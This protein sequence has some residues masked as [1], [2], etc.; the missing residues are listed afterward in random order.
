MNSLRRL[1]TF[2]HPYRWRYALAALLTTLSIAGDLVTP[3]LFGMTV[4]RGLAS[5][6]MSLVLFYAGLLLVAQ[7]IRSLVNYVQWQVQHRVGQDVVRDMRDSLY[8]KLQSLPTSFYRAMPTGQIMS[9]M[10]SDIDAIQEYLGWGLMIQFAALISF[11]GTAIVL[12]V[13]DPG[14]TSVLL[15]P[16][17]PL[18]LIVLLYDRRIAPAWE[19]IRDHMGELT[20]ALQ[21]N[22]SGV[23]VV[24]A[25][26]K[27]AF[28][29]LKFRKENERQKEYNLVRARIEGSAIPSMDLMIGIAFVLLA[30]YGAQ[31]V[32]N[33]E[34]TLGT[35]FAYQWYLWGIIWPVRFM[36]WLIS[37]MREAMGAAPRIFE[38]LDANNPIVDKQDAAQL[39]QIHGE[40]EFQDVHFAF[41]DEPERAVFK[42]LELHMTPGEVIAILGGTGSGKSSLINLI[43][44]F[45][46]VTGGRL[47]VDGHDVRDV[48]LDSLRAQIA[49]VP[50]EPFLFSS[51][52]RN[53]IAYG[54]PEA[55]MEEIVAAAELARAHDFILDLEKGYDTLVGERGIGLSGGQKQ[56]LALARAILMNPRILILDEATSAVDTETEHAIQQAMEQVMQGRT[57]LIIAQRL[58]TIKHADRIVVLKDGSVAEDGTHEEL[59][60]RGGEYARI[61]NL[62]YRE[63]DELEK[64]IVAQVAARLAAT[65]GFA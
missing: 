42:G 22:L 24:K 45:Q 51:T 18:A 44:R 34:T 13:I 25:F 36:G 58:S 20:T 55:T 53:N 9:R 5:G 23:R 15:L 54:R 31:R 60:A 32:I 10:T 46:D 19:R 12:F 2:L 8:S 52:I 62:Q 48:Q 26:A 49:V 38:V 41:D 65:P 35:F 3:W 64:Q 16:M 40:I 39:N 28:E 33:G 56:R 61:Y 30:W 63:Q 59:L 37:I 11:F 47:L 7:A 1:I 27:E 6:E 57:S 14:L 4:D 29:T 21:E 50:Q 17:L 43:P